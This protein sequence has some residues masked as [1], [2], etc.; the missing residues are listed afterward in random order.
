[1][2]LVENVV[3]QH[4]KHKSYVAGTSVCETFDEVLGRFGDRPRICGSKPDGR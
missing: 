1:V 2:F 3:L 4:I